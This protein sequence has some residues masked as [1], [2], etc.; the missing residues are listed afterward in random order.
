MRGFLDMK[1]DERTHARTSV[2]PQASA[3]E[4]ER[5]KIMKTYSQVW[6]I[7]AENT[8]KWLFWP[9][10]AKFGQFWGQKNF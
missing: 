6:N 10:M 9:K 1:C 5:P 2:N 7:Q 3:A 8:Q 4:A